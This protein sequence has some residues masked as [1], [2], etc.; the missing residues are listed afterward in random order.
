MEVNMGRLLGEKGRMVIFALILII[1][2]VLTGCALLPDEEIR[3]SPV[4][5]T[6][7]KTEYELEIAT[8]RDLVNFKNINCTYEQLKD[9]AL[10]FGIGDLGVSKVYVETGDEVKKGDLLAEL[11]MG[12]IDDQIYRLR[13]QIKVNEITLDYTKELMRLEIEKQLLLFENGSLN[14]ELYH[15]EVANIRDSYTATIN[16]IEETLYLDN[17]ALDANKA[18]RDQGRIYAGMD[19]IVTYVKPA[20]LWRDSIKDEV[21]IRVIDNKQFAFKADTEYSSYFQEGDIVDITL[22]LGGK[23][24]EAKVTHD[25]ENPN[26]IYFELL[27]PVFELGVGARGTVTLILEEKNDV[28]SV[29]KGAIRSTEEFQYVYYLN[30]DGIRSM[31]KVTVGME[32]SEFVEI[33]SGLETGDIIIKR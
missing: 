30:E 20:L 17:L 33:T 31:K 24:Y 23:V 3:P 11:H 5:H 13:H 8:K 9:E 28:L 15:K 27:E 1:G 25:R 29:S 12:D 10:S 22:R 26:I 18:K 16:N 32:T 2:Q 14:Q 4:V 7:A 19:G 21:V 6:M